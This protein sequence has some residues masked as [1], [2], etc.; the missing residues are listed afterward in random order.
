M[1]LLAADRLR[2][3]VTEI[4]DVPLEWIARALAAIKAENAAE[5]SQHGQGDRRTVY[6]APPGTT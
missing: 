3:P 1:L 6:G 5:A 2:I 4:G